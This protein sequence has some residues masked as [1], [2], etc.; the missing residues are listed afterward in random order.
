MLLPKANAPFWPAAKLL[1]LPTEY[2]FV[3]FTMLG[4][5]IAP[6]F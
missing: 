5:P 3:A 6:E 4:S 1:L 2:E